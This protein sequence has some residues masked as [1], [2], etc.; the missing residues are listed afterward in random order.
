MLRPQRS[1]LSSTRVSRSAHRPRRRSYARFRLGIAGKLSRFTGAFDLLLQFLIARF[2]PLPP[3]GRKLGDNL[4]KNAAHLNSPS[5]W[6]LADPDSLRPLIHGLC[7]SPCSRAYWPQTSFAISMM[8]ESFFHCSS[9]ASVLP[10]SV[11][12][13]PHWGERQS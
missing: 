11:E 7:S 1:V 6:I 12:A 2:H 9:S 3:L 10:S 4:V 8:R 13:K 5:I